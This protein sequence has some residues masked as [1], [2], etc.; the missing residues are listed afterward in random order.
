MRIGVVAARLPV[1]RARGPCEAH[2]GCR[3]FCGRRLAGLRG[4]VAAAARAVV[5]TNQGS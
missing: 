3:N 5:K 1:R 4:R 2:R